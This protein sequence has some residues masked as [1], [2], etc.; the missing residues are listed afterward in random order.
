MVTCGQQAIIYPLCNLSVQKRIV[1]LNGKVFKAGFNTSCRNSYVKTWKRIPS[2]LKS[3]VTLPSVYVCVFAHKLHGNSYSM[4][5]TCLWIQICF[6]FSTQFSNIPHKL[7]PLYRQN[8][9]AL[10]EECK[11][12]VRTG[13][14]IFSWHSNIQT[15]CV[16]KFCI[17]EQAKRW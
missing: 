12:C 11:E 4:L 10:D 13:Q 8:T 7:E 15:F 1:L 9:W 3:L 16:W 14:F 6:S 17:L 5:C 2:Y